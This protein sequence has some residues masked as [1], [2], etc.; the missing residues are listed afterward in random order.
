MLDL[1]H[2]P[3]TGNGNID[4]FYNTGGTSWVTWEK[5]EEFIR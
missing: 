3:K 2:L 1:N 5:Q 4:Y